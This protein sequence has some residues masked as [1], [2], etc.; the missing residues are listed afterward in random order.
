MGSSFDLTSLPIFVQVPASLAPIPTTVTPDSTNLFLPPA[1]ERNFVRALS[2]A[3][4]ELERVLGPGDPVVKKIR[5]LPPIP[6]TVGDPFSPT[7]GSV[8]LP[9]SEEEQ[10]GTAAKIST[11]LASYPVLFLAVLCHEY[12]HL[13]DPNLR[14]AKRVLTELLA[15][16]P[17]D[18][19]HP[20]LTR[21]WAR[22]MARLEI[23]AHES[24][25]RFLEAW[26]VS[27]A[28]PLA[29][30]Q[31]LEEQRLAAIAYA[32]CGV[33]IQ[34]VGLVALEVFEHHF[35]SVGGIDY[36]RGSDIAKRCAAELH[37][38]HVQMVQR[39][40]EPH[41]RPHAAGETRDFRSPSDAKEMV[42]RSA[43]LIG[44]LLRHGVL[45]SSKAADLLAPYPE[46]IRTVGEQREAFARSVTLAKNLS[47]FTSSERH[48]TGT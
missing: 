39:L 35:Q 22:T 37:Q 45:P 21:T 8:A 5:E 26:Q 23:F 6:R 46:W 13:L 48:C 4:A 47:L 44:E 41:S 9:R 15:T 25:L 43:V 24:E 28:V 38:L 42:Q 3:V 2:W 30:Q 33:A 34:K 18:P 27:R 19:R 20:E 1:H 31:S 29:V 7:I 12:G 14:F 17:S 40:Y 11:N 16:A 10:F 32:R 36:S